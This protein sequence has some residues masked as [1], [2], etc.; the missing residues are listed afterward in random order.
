MGTVFLAALAASAVVTCLVCRLG[1]RA[2][3]LDRPNSRSSHASPTPT[4]GGLGLV[5]GFWAGLGLGV[6]LGSTDPW[7]WPVFAGS[8]AVLLVMAW[9]EVRPMG[10]GQKLIVQSVAAAV[11]LSCGLVLRALPIPFMPDLALG[12]AAYPVTFVWLVAV[13]NAYNFMD[14]IDGIAGIEALVVAGF[15]ALVAGAFA[16]LD[17]VG[18]LA[19]AGAAAGFLIWNRPPARVFMGDV[20]SHFLGLLFGTY[21]LILHQRGLPFEIIPIALGV[22]LYDTGYTIVRRALRGE[23]IT[24]AHRFHLYQRLNA[25]GWSPGR[26]DLAYCGLTVCLCA[27]AYCHATG[28]GTAAGVLIG[29]AAGVLAIGTLWVEY[30]WRSRPEAA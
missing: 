20:G 12:V 16:P 6:V 15:T 30:R 8:S 11:P 22:F 18:P 7:I 3:V 27:G 1:W 19:C 23:N 25:T 28:R 13:Q 5:A 4:M 29:V 24:L 17:A 2:G 21:A 10:R 9:D 26:V 14:G